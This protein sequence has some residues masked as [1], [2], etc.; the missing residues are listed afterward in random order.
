MKLCS[1]GHHACTYR[2]VVQGGQLRAQDAYKATADW[3]DANA[4]MIART[5]ESSE[6]DSS[7]GRMPPRQ[8]SPPG[9]GG[10]PGCCCWCRPLGP[11][12]ARSDTKRTANGLLPG[13]ML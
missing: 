11:G 13:P 3:Q 5:E 4:T 9:R 10:P 8:E 2:G 1:R 12:E 6:A 7:G